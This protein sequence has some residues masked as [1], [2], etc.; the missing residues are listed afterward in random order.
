M[1]ASTW[2]ADVLVVAGLA[3]LTAAVIGLLR[4]PDPRARIHAASMA[5]AGGVGLVLAA[6][7]V[8][9]PAATG[10]RALLAAVFVFLT[11]PVGSHALARLAHMGELDDAEPGAGAPA[12]ARRG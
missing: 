7:V 5:V 2:A 10:A 9:Q 1:S 8:A 4:L 3:V 11:A 12:K 6:C